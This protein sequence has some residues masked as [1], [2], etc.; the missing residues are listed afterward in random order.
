MR[1]FARALVLAVTAWMAPAVGCSLFVSTSDLTGGDARAGDASSAQDGRADGG[2]FTY[3][4]VT[5]SQFWSSF[6]L[7]TIG[8][9]AESFTG[10]TS[11][12]RYL[13]FPPFQSG[14]ATTVFTGNLLR[15]DMQGTF[16]DSSA[17]TT[18]D[19]STVNAQCVGFDGAV[20][21]GRWLYL[22][23]SRY[24]PENYSGTSTRYDTQA[25][26]ASAS[27]YSTIDLQPLASS[28]N[29][30]SGGGFDGRY[31]YLGTQYG[32]AARYDTSQPYG[33]LT[34]WVTLDPRTLSGSSTNAFESAMYD[35]QRYLYFLPNP[36]DGTD[37]AVRYDTSGPLTAGS[38]WEKFSI[39]S[40]HDIDSR[41]VIFDGR[42]VYYSPCVDSTNAY[43][44]VVVRYDTQG[45]F[46]DASSWIGYDL[47]AVDATAQGFSGGVFDGRYAYFIPAS[48]DTLVRYDT[49]APFASAS[50]W[51]VVSTSKLP[52][53]GQN[54][55]G[56]YFDGKYV[57][58]FPGSVYSSIALR[59][60]ARA[61]Q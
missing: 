2:V 53:T 59:F 6:D 12:G 28:A 14:Q 22:A 11:D 54:F 23:P 26:F 25:P 3:H 9:G 42:Y 56:A 40:V 60:D 32:V 51:T 58:L 15:L 7:G 4:D 43:S 10:A 16:T 18:F 45:A 8:A 39:S 38:S 37:D 24:N 52:G 57:Y 49:L 41:G 19:L 13:Y 31:V 47:S 46:G 50:S 5:S 17:W 48:N 21:D 35:G 1:R 29:G 20:F 44:G 27:S 55:G 33:S 61:P 34:S 36:N 30:F